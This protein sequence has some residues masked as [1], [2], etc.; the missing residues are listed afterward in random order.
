MKIMFIATECVPYCKIAGVADVVRGLARELQTQ[1]NDVRIIIPCYRGL[2]DRSIMKEIVTEM[3]VP[4]GSYSREVSVWKSNGKQTTYLIEQDFYFDR[5]NF[6]GYL[7]DYERFLFFTR[8]TLEL[9]KNDDFQKKE[10]WF[11]EIIQGFDWVT[12]FV[13]LWIAENIEDSRFAQTRFILSIQNIKDTGIFSGRSLQTAQQLS[14]GYFSEIGEENERISFLGRGIL[15]ADRVVTVNPSFNEMN[16]LPTSA[17]YLSS[18]ID[19]KVKMGHFIGIRNAIDYE[20]FDP[21]ED[22]YITTKFKEQT[23]DDRRKNKLYLQEE[24]N[25]EIDENIPMVGIVSQLIQEKGFDLFPEFLKDTVNECNFQFVALL[26]PKNVEYTALFQEWENEWNKKQGN[27]KT[28]RKLSFSFDERLARKIYSACDIILL[29]FKEAPC[30][31]Q[32]FIAMH[33]GA[34][35][36]IHETGAL[37]DSIV[38]YSP[39]MNLDEITNNGVGFSFSE[40]SAKAFSK[41]LRDALELY[42]NDQQ[43]WNSIQRHNMQVNFSW[44]QPAKQFIKLY[45]ESLSKD[46]A[47]V[48]VGTP[49]E[50][51]PDTQLFQTLMEI[52][53]LPGLHG[54]DHRELFRHVARL[55]RETIR[56]DAVYVWTLGESDLSHTQDSSSFKS[57]FVSSLNDFENH[58]SHDDF[59]IQK[60]LN[61][62]MTGTFMG[63]M[64]Y[65]PGRI[66]QPIPCLNTSE[67]AQRAQWEQGW[68]VPIIAHHRVFGRID[69]LF[70]KDPNPLDKDW[71]L[72]ALATIAI[73]FG[74]RFDQIQREQEIE[75]ISETTKELFNTHSFT[76]AMSTVIERAKKIVHAEDAWLYL[77]NES[78]LS[79]VA[80]TS[81]SEAGIEIAISSILK[82]KVIYIP[83]LSTASNDLRKD[84]FPYRSLLVVPL[85]DSEKKAIGVLELV[86][87][88][89]AAFSREEEQSLFR[90]FA[91]QAAAALKINQWHTMRNRLMVEHLKKLSTS[92]IGGGDLDRLLNNI[93]N[94]T[95]HLLTSKTAGLFLY[96]KVT[97]T[98]E[99]KASAG[100]LRSAADQEINFITNDEKITT[101]QGKDPNVY[102]LIPLKIAEC[103]TEKEQLIGF[104]K[105]EDRILPGCMFTDDEIQLGE[106]MASIIGIVIYNTQLSEDRLRLLS[107]NITVLS[108]AL[109][110]SRDMSTLMDNLVKK[111]AIVLKV[112]A[113]SLYLADEKGTELTIQAA[114]GYQEPLVKEN[115][116]YTWGQGVTGTI[117]STKKAIVAQSLEELRKY[118]GQAKRGTYDHLHKEQFQPRSFYGLPL[119][120]KEKDHSIGVLKVESTKERFFSTEDVLLIEMMA[121]VIATVV[122]NVQESER[123][124][125]D[126]SISLNALSGVLTG[127]RDMSTL[128]DNI[129]KRIALVLK[130]DAASLYLADEKGTV[131]TIQAAAG[132]QEPLVKEMAKYT[133]GQGVTGTIAST[134]KAIVTRS[135]EELREYGG[136]AKRGTY[137]HLHKELFQPRSFYGLPLVVREKE[138]AIGVLK[139][140]STKER[141]FS[142]EDILLI[143]MMAKVIATVV[144]NVQ[145]SEQRLRD[146]SISLNDLSGVL[147]G[148]RDMSTLMDNLVKKI[149]VVLKVDAA[150]LYLADEKGT[151]LTIQA[152]AGYQEPLVKEKVKYTWG[153]G[154]TGTIAS[155]KNAIVTRSLEELREYGGQAKRGTYDHLHKELFQPR[156]FYGLPLVVREK[157]HAIGVLKV[158]STKER[159]FSNEDVLLIEMMAKVIATVVYNAQ[160][161]EKHI[162]K[163]LQQLGSLSEPATGAVPTLLGDLARE[164]EPGVL[165]Q[166]GK[167]IAAI[168][169]K[170]PDFCEKEI[171]ALFI[172][173][174]QVDLYERIALWSQNEQVKWT[175]S[176]YHRILVKRRRYESWVDLQMFAESWIKLKKTS[177]TPASFEY[178]VLDL[179]AKITD[180]FHID[181]E[182]QQTDRSQTWFGSL[183]NTEKIFGTAIERIPLIFQRNGDIDEGN[184]DLLCNF[185]KTGFRRSY[186]VFILLL[187]NFSSPT[188]Q[189]Q[190]LIHRMKLHAIDVVIT[191][192]D[193]FLQ[194][195]QSINPVETFRSLV[196]RQVKITSPFVIVGPVPDSL[197]F[198]RE[199]ELREITEYIGNGRSCVI[200]GGRRIG[201]TSILSRLARVRLPDSGF[202]TLYHDCSTT[203]SFDEFL[204]ASVQSLKPQPTEA[205]YKTIKDL[206]ATPPNGGNLVLLLDEA[207]ELISFDRKNDW[208]LFKY[209]RALGNAGKVLVVL[210]GERYIQYALQENTSPLFNLSNPILLGPLEFNDVEE[211][212]TKPMKQ[213]EIELVDEKSII[214]QMY[215]FT[216]GH[217]N[218]VQRLCRQLI[219]LANEQNLR[220]I[221]VKEIEQITTD[222]EF[223]EKDFLQTYWERATPLEKIITLIMIKQDKPYRLKEV[224]EALNSINLDPTPDVVKA[225]L[226][227]LVNLRS[228]LKREQDGYKF[229]VRAFPSVIG[230]TTTAEDL[231]LTLTSKYLSNPSEEIDK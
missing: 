155:T 106:M 24:Y 158:E 204:A 160:Q 77:Q 98:L 159:F 87:K 205:N 16:P 53:S 152:A 48:K 27:G 134:K 196:L 203:P 198:G 60:L 206:L 70:K 75:Q 154:V 176:L 104:L 1:G 47:P 32:Q 221:T 218:I 66:C 182:E 111:I 148:G 13:P 162:E 88:Q 141:F 117:A 30:V 150:S 226:D 228:I 39:G 64:N 175:F 29:P 18:I 213:L 2:L 4:I 189:I 93:V 125:R 118:G 229:A 84:F 72:R 146:F 126:F 21:R 90:Y 208:R 225:A 156:S 188:S 190:S 178:S 122:Y 142:N 171:K 74:F 109:V 151:V 20:E 113:A 127:G 165:D 61:I 231:L 181:R 43:V 63:S 227:R 138:H 214:Q 101:F 167:S 123:R 131:L 180:I 100:I 143:E 147:T 52:D 184:I 137:D 76:E 91:P 153:Q 209:L 56:C 107:S 71:I 54:R 94:T 49:I 96:N 83:D 201:K 57:Q 220:K 200:L 11:P 110:G 202:S 40:F 15:F 23:L 128:M 65:D 193:D 42:R 79:P 22:P 195:L 212:V 114:A 157:E 183:L 186:N 97:E 78:D 86:K 46:R 58:S 33:Y 119:V 219:K 169:D 99:L 102:L 69:I 31:A 28:I 115:V 149:A 5:D 166:L 215:E 37:K 62:S 95:I 210:C 145:E 129:V 6:Y 133:W 132:Y 164:Q 185:V 187:W 68:S 161:N 140:E 9:L 130:V 163:I 172:A 112:D 73:S 59:E 197:F 177:P 116:K 211:L 45:K 10:N 170:K 34:L 135:L 173:N 7:D 82:N 139:V 67:L 85:V 168:I 179:V 124:L 26:D 223:Q 230:H 120:V 35:P 89:P 222:P 108:E 136:Q 17:Q 224:I 192:I 12:G 36:L 25:F 105:I 3:P 121:N 199:K 8:A 50:V 92:L 44:F 19:T 81:K 191:G 80:S 194:I 41:A 144:Y 51:D 174:A 55:V 14:K 103:C 207:D 216:S 38:S 217:P